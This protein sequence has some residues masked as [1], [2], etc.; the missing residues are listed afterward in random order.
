MSLQAAD[1]MLGDRVLLQRVDRGESETMGGILIPDQAQELGDCAEVIAVG[2]GAKNSD[3][4]RE[5]MET[6]PGELVMINRYAGTT[7]SKNGDTFLVVRE[8]DILAKVI[9]GEPNVEAA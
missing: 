6:E 9:E 8:Q 3:G 7:Y 2:A 1:V 5:P 4:S